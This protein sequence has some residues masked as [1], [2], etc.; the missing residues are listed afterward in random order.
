MHHIDEVYNAEYQSCEGR[1]FPKLWL[2]K[3]LQGSAR[4]CKALQGSAKEAMKTQVS[5]FSPFSI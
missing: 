3:A 5:N 1:K 4:L 2:C